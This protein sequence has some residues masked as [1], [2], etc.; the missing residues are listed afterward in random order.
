MCLL[1][2]FLVRVW[3]R[4]WVDGGRGARPGRGQ[5]LQWGVWETD[6]LLPVHMGSSLN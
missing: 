4:E 2:V 5:G 6:L 1:F 3:G